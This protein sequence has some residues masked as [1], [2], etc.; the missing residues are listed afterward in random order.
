MK[1][2]KILLIEDEENE[3]LLYKEEL[4]KEGFS[5]T[6]CENGSKA[7]NF[8]EKEDFDL[9]ILDSQMPQMDGI[10]TLGKMLTKKRNLPIIIYTAYPQYKDQFLTWA[11]DAYIIKSADLSQ[12]KDKV[13][14]I[15][16]TK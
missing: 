12:L 8:I 5:V 15:L 4:E 6:C 13:H 11:A 2:K 10:E 7:I 1:N 14:S 16:N 3:R 9:V